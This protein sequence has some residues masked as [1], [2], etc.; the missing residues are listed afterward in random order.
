MAFAGFIAGVSLAFPISGPI[1]AEGW[2]GHLNGAWTLPD[3]TC[4]DIFVAEGGHWAFH[5]PVDMFG[6]SFIVEVRG[7]EARCRIMRAG[8]HDSKISLVV[9]CSNSVSFTQSVVELVVKNDNEVERH[10]P[11]S[12]E[13]TITFKKCPR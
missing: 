4:S 9:S 1:A 3:N 12:D 5:K 8:E 11:G 6:P 13:L 2:E 10:F 7:P